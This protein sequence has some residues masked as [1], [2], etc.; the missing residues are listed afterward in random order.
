MFIIKFFVTFFAVVFTGV[1]ASAE[2]LEKKEMTI[3]GKS[4]IVEKVKDFYE[5]K[6]NGKKI[7]EEKYIWKV[8]M[9]GQ[10]IGTVQCM[11]NTKPGACSDYYATWLK[12]DASHAKNFKSLDE[13][14]RHLAGKE[15]KSASSSQASEW[16]NVSEARLGLFFEH[17]TGKT[18]KKIH[19]LEVSD[20][21]PANAKMSFDSKP[22]ELWN[23]LQI[24]LAN[25]RIS[26]IQVMVHDKKPMTYEKTL[27]IL[28]KMYGDM[29]GNIASNKK[30]TVN[31]LNGYKYTWTVGDSL[32]QRLIVIFHNNRQYIFVF[33]AFK[34]H[35]EYLK[36]IM[37]KMIGSIK[38]T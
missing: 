29:P 35:Y 30:F 17:P 38:L 16:T 25:D 15:R 21:L 18:V 14:V 34:E 6:L 4:V 23:S 31:G 13:S 26:P 10:E 8:L 22:S 9:Q 37:E 32:Q 36:P 27:S 11:D 20:F 19:K 1:V 5:W 33:G 12:G 28:K 24:E 7:K 2:T 3:D